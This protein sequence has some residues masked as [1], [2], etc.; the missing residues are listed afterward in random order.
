MGDDSSANVKA[1]S[2]GQM[3][4]ANEIFAFVSAY[5]QVDAGAG[6]ARQ[7]YLF[8]KLA[9]ILTPPPA[10]ASQNVK[11]AYREENPKGYLEAFSFA[12]NE[13]KFDIDLKISD[14]IVKALAGLSGIALEGALLEEVKNQ[15]AAGASPMLETKYASGETVAGCIL[16]PK[17]FVDDFGTVVVFIS[18]FQL[19]VNNKSGKIL[20]LFESSELSA[21]YTYAGMGVKSPVITK[22]VMTEPKLYP[23]TY[24]PKVPV[25]LIL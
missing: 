20:G 1:L 17:C 7:Y 6:I 2:V 19:S 22:S 10:N 23:S 11:D 5:K 4:T 8:D 3:N 24:V 25:N 13:Q 9:R 12:V 16:S 15:V 21:K 14:I 18:N